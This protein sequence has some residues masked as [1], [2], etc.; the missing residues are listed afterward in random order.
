MI[1][2]GV[3]ELEPM[4]SYSRLL[5][6]RLA[7][8]FGFAH[9]SVGE[10]DD[11]HL[12]LERS[13]ETSI[14]SILVSDILWQYGE[15]QP[16][17]TSHQLLRR[18]EA[19][20]VL[21]SQSPSVEHTF[22]E[23]EAAYL[24]ARERIF[25]TDVGAVREPVRQKPRNVPDAARRMI[26]H[27]LGQKVKTRTQPDVTKDDKESAQLANEVN[28]QNNDKARPNSS[29]ETY[30]ETTS[31]P[32]RN[33]NFRGKPKGNLQKCRTPSQSD[34][35]TTQEPAEMRC[36]NGRESQHGRSKTSVSKEYSKA[37]H[38]G[39]A[40]RMFAQALGLHSAKDGFH[41]KCNETK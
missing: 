21:S 7:D 5:L 1:I 41:L 10:G 12:I 36:T 19:P 37:E 22:E 24:A 34:R 28:T 39:A 27:A 6:H 31:S 16:V 29:S 17:T 11:R 13:H 18:K 3:L 30:Q 20:P 4:N 38:L 14:P 33:T 25:S 40:K 26:A 8:I 15:P 35:T 9:E 32:G 2:D 23:R